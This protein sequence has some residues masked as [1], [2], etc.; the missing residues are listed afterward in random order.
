MRLET[1]I[2]NRKTLVRALE[3]YTMSSARY[4]G[5][6]SFAYEI[7][8]I[9]VARNGDVIGSD[10]AGVKNYLVEHGIISDEAELHEDMPAEFETEVE[11][12]VQDTIGLPEMTEET[13]AISGVTQEETSEAEESEEPEAAGAIREFATVETIAPSEPVKQEEAYDTEADAG[14]SDTEQ[15]E[16]VEESQPIQELE[17]A[18]E[19]AL[20]EL[21]EAVDIGMPTDGLTAFQM[22]NLIYMLY[23]KQYILGRALGRE[24]IQISEQVIERLQQE[25]PATLGDL[26][27]MLDDFKALGDLEGIKLTEQEIFLTF[28]TDT[29]DKPDLKVYTALL[30]HIVEAAKQATRVKIDLQKPENEK[31]YMR[32]WLLRLGFGSAQHKEVR[33]RLM[34]D[35][36]GH[37]AFAT[38]EQAQAHREKYKEIRRIK[39]EVDE[40]AE[41]R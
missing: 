22:R 21:P 32:G 20:D 6:P 18:S 10:L 3:Q 25:L 4:Q 14:E 30:T 7:D 33:K 17:D 23:G 35:L 9:T 8:G 24:T 2:T 27:E 1:N 16:C 36:K 12:Q 5:P 26:G 11:Q 19:E 28:P 13:T 38:E 31:Y 29:D 40:E 39:H 15:S 41:E 34:R 37:A